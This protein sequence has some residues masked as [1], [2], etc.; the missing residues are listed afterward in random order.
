M[1]ERV[2]DAADWR[3][4]SAEFRYC[5]E[6]AESSPDYIGSFALD[7]LAMS[8]HCVWTTQSLSAALL[9]AANLRGD[10]DTVAAITGQLAGAMYGVDGMETSWREAVEQWDG[11]G[12][13]A[14]RALALLS[15]ATS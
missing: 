5:T 11:G 8:L 13:V 6:R 2:S 1:G 3:W 9:K 10:A 12:D 7:A 4:R 15:P 14:A